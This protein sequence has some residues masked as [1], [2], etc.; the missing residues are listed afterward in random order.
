[1]QFR[2]VSDLNSKYGPFIKNHKVVNVCCEPT[3]AT[4][5]YTAYKYK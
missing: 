5:T 4:S 1:M 2:L 3:N